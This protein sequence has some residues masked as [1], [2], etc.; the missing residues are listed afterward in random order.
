MFDDVHVVIKIGHVCIVVCLYFF[1]RLLS[2]IMAMYILIMCLDPTWFIV[3]IFLC[4]WFPRGL[5][6]YN[7]VNHE[8]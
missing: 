3:V 4:N 6:W 2:T 7:Y 8:G 5:S 1:C